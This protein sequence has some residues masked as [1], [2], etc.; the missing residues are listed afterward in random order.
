MSET[1]ISLGPSPDQQAAAFDRAVERHRKKTF[2][3]DKP[4]LF[5]STLRLPPDLDAAITK[6][7]REHGIDRSA[8]IKSLL[9]RALNLPEQ[10]P[11]DPLKDA[12]L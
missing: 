3:T 8:V 4:R 10:A 2:M 5:P 6:L 1:K 7:A 11:K 9:R 12:G